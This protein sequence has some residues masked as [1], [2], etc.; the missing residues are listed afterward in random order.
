MKNTIAQLND[1]TGNAHDRFIEGRNKL[2]EARALVLD[3]MCNSA[4]P[5]GKHLKLTKLH[6]QMMKLD[7]KLCKAAALVLNCGGAK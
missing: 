4:L 5:T 7:D 2:R 6:K 1:D 3:A